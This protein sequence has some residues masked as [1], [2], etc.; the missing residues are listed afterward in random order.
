VI[1]L[2][3]LQPGEQRDTAKAMAWRLG[4]YTTVCPFDRAITHVLFK[5]NPLDKTATQVSVQ[6][7]DDRVSFVDIAWLETCAQDGKRL[8]SSTFLQARVHYN[9]V[10]DEAVKRGDAGLGGS[11]GLHRRPS[12][13]LTMATSDTM[14]PLPLPAP[15]VPSSSSSSAPVRSGPPQPA[16][17]SPPLVAQGPFAGLTL[18]LLGWAPEDDVTKEMVRKICENGGTTV[19]GSAE[20]VLEAQVNTCICQGYSTPDVGQK[21]LANFATI[22]WVDACVAEGICH[23]ITN[24][25]HFAPGPGPLPLQDMANCLVRI[26]AL[27][28]SDNRKRTRLQELVEV[29][30]AKVA[31]Q[32]SKWGEIT[33]VV[34]VMPEHLDRKMYEVACKKNVPTVSVQWLFDCFSMNSRQPEAKYDVANVLGKM[35]SQAKISSETNNLHSSRS[36][37]AEV[38]S[39]HD[40][41]V[42]PSALGSDARL[43][44]MAEELGGTVQT[45]RSPTE[46]AQL[47][48]SCEVTPSEPSTAGTLG[49]SAGLA[50][51]GAEAGGNGARSSGKRRHVVVLL[52][53]EEVTEGTQLATF[54]AKLGTE[55]REIFVVPAWLSE[56]FQ[57]RRRLPLEAFAALP[58]MED[59]EGAAAKRQRLGSGSLGEAAYAWQPAS[60]K[61]LE[62]LAE[63]SRARALQSIAEQK[64]N[65]GLRLAELR[66]EPSRL[67]G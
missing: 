51:S 23:S 25:L 8:P 17:R 55:R 20:S 32:S 62:E 30:G 10:C 35:D 19:Y 61:S 22:K 18:G 24:F 47:L 29:L 21:V 56:T 1:N 4:A 37:N 38:L 14:L 54:I 41:L 28:A 5:V 9:P 2:L 64:V 67:G 26:T 7:D 66:R 11:A 50:S 60:L 53:K 3:Y 44:Q 13:A 46:F 65:E 40:V 31:K 6:V 34:C 59:S 27:G 39:G 36:F 42:S 58:P 45:W 48:A 49:S 33:H 52:D 15:Q 63:D 12:R 16:L 43:P 57:Q